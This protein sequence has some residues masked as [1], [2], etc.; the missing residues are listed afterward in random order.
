MEF[1]KLFVFV[2]FGNVWLSKFGNFSEKKRNFWTRKIFAKKF[3][4]KFG[5]LSWEKFRILIEIVCQ[6][7]KF[8]KN[9][10]K[11]EFLSQKTLFLG[12]KARK[13]SEKVQKYLE[14]VWKSLE[15]VFSEHSEISV[16]VL[17]RN[18]K[19]YKKMMLNSNFENRE[20]LV[21]TRKPTRKICTY[22][23]SLGTSRDVEKVLNEVESLNNKS[24][25]K[26][27]FISGKNCI[28]SYRGVF[29]LQHSSYFAIHFHKVNIGSMFRQRN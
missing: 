21:S 22:L 5:N 2:I 15:T 24:K 16:I 8:Q 14:K 17:F 28:Q 6:L 7:Q 26:V 27:S 4:K 9:Y 1:S 19:N 18:Y 23:R 11:F 20:K 29:L 13:S 10:V 12:Q 3:G 25:I